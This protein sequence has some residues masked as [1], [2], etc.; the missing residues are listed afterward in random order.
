M[1]MPFSLTNTAA[2]FQ[3]AVDILLAR[4]NWKSCVI[5]LKD[6]IV[7]SSNLGEHL[8]HVR[9]VLQVLQ[10]ADITLKLNNCELF[11]DTLKHLGY[12]ICTGQ[13]SIHGVR[14]RSF[15]ET[16]IPTAQTEFRSFLGFC[17]VY[18]RLI[19]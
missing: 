1:R 15:E 4:S 7:F 6:I 2:T 12:T 19:P 5:Y 17:N 3:R 11:T 13:L 8:E 9:D 18:L 14:V 16:K 10:D